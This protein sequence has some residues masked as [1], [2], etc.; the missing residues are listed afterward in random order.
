MALLSTPVIMIL[1]I[2]STSE[3][4]RNGNMLVYSALLMHLYNVQQSDIFACYCDNCHRNNNVLK[5]KAQA[6]NASPHG[7]I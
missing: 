3:K 5:V 7:A 4:V 1:L 2:T 6:Q